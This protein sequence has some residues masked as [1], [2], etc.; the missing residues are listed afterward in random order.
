MP[1]VL[2]KCVTLTVISSN[3]AGLC[4]GI[5]VFPLAPDAACV[6]RGQSVGRFCLLHCVQLCT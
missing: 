2:T 5:D 4:Q 1:A 3:P 6:E